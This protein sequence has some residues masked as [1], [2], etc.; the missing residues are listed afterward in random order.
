[1]IAEKQLNFSG[2]NFAPNTIRHRNQNRQLDDGS[3]LNRRVVRDVANRARRIR[4]ARMMVL[5]R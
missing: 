3:R 1:M 2:R 5:E 4:A